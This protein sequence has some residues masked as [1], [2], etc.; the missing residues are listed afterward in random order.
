MSFLVNPYSFTTAGFTV[1]SDPGGVA[2]DDLSGL[3]LWLKA[4]NTQF[5]GVADDTEISGTW[6]DSSGNAR[7]ATAVAAGS[8]ATFPKFKQTAGPNSYPAIRLVTDS[9]GSPGGWFTLPDFLTSFTSGSYFAVVILDE[10]PPDHNTSPPLGDWA[11]ATDDSYYPFSDTKI[12]D[13]W[14]STARK[15]AIVVSGTTS[16]HVYEVRTASAAWSC[17]KDGTQLHSTGTN[18]VGWGTAPK[19]G[20]VATNT[21]FIEGMI[22]EVIFYS[23]VLSSSDRFNTVHTYLN[24]KYGFALPT[25]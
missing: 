13:K 7:D 3:E 22:A 5:N 20:R 23:S 11:P 15:D 24:N 21:K 6:N 12:Y 4:N 19:V 10:E 9:A 25:S 17:H 1:P 2:P 16:W 8:V 14:G 18:T